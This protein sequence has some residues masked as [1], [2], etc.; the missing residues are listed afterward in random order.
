MLPATPTER[1]ADGETR[2]LD[3]TP[4]K[5]ALFQLSYISVVS[6]LGVVP[7]SEAS[8]AIEGRSTTYGESWE[9]RDSNPQ[10]SV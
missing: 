10:H 5:G 4:T 3:L 7:R 9:R 2:T 1:E 6:P 8:P